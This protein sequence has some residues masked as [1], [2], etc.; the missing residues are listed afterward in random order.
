MLQ[1]GNDTMQTVLLQ[2]S[3]T[4]AATVSASRGTEAVAQ[5]VHN[6][7]SCHDTWPAA[8]PPRVLAAL[9]TSCMRKT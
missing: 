8:T 1:G 6:K 3:A 2:L 9:V 5:D 4:Q 7:A